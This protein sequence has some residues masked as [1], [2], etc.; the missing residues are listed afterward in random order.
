VI[1]SPRSIVAAILIFAA[2]GAV[3]VL[4]TNA[5]HSYDTH[6]EPGF[7]RIN[8]YSVS[9][10][11]RTLVFSTPVGAGDV[12]LGHEVTEAPDTVTLIVRS[13]VL[14][15]G[16]NSFKNL[17]ATLDT[18][19]IVLKEPLGARRV[20]DGATGKIVARVARVD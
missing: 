2:G 20:V 15:P 9:A 11:G 14:V 18:T 19:M 1:L 12:L 5:A 13:S 7:A 10:D 8:G 6:Y 4:A 17:S 3:G 16:R